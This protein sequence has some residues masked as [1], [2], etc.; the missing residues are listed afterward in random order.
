MRKNMNKDISIAKAFD[1]INGHPALT[2]YFDIFGFKSINWNIRAVC[3]RGY[4]KDEPIYIYYNGKGNNGRWESEFENITNPE[5]KYLLKHYD[6][7]FNEPWVFDH[8]EYCYEIIFNV[9]VGDK[10]NKDD[11]LN[12][13]KWQ[14]FVGPSDKAMS[15][16]EMILKIEKDIKDAFGDFDNYSCWLTEEE[17]ENHKTER[18]FSIIDHEMVKNDKYIPVDKEEINARWFKWFVESSEFAKKYEF[19]QTLNKGE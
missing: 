18:A 4:A 5:F 6:D 10:N 2:G 14:T 16:D 11:I 3:F 13:E 15:F 1:F 17:K 19:D 8:I 7:V 9:F 12:I